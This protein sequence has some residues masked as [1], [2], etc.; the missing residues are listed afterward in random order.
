M[1]WDI[2]NKKPELNLPKPVELTPSLQTRQQTV[3][4]VKLYYKDMTN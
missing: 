4:H 1:L 2:L 3:E